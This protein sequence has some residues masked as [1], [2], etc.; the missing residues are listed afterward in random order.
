VSKPDVVIIG[1]WM[2][3]ATFA[4]AIAPSGRRIL[5]L[6]KGQPLRPSHQDRDARAIFARGH[7]RP[8]EE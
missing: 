1:S 2:G 3:G 5:I 8:N 6:E 4:A 7:F